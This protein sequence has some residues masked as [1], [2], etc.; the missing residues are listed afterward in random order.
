MSLV[1]AVN[2]A[3]ENVLEAVVVVV[4]DCDAVGKAHPC[5]AGL[6]GHVGEIALAV[7]LEEAVEVFGG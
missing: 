6:F 3:D 5:K 4:S 1:I 2:P 7:I